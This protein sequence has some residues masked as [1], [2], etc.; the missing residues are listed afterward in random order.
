M[1]N[2]CSA[3][4]RVGALALL[5]PMLP[6]CSLVSPRGGLPQVPADLPPAVRQ[7]DEAEVDERLA[8]LVERL[9][10]R[11]DWA[12]YWQNG[13]TV[14]YGLGIVIQGTRAG[15]TDHEGKQADFTVSA[16]KAIGG[17]ANLLLRPIQ[18]QHG[19]DRV[20]ELP[21]ATVDD[22]RRRLVM[23]EEQLRINAEEAKNRWHWIRHALNVAVNAA[24]AVIV[25]KGFDDRTRAWRSFGVG[26]AVGE[27]MILSAPW[28]PEDDWDEY[29]S[30]FGAP[31]SGTKVSWRVVPTFGG[32][33]LEIS[34]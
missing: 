31:A 13:W 17:T 18:A 22:R 33:Q 4:A 2:S 6:A 7:L 27:A 14:F 10:H 20:R 16:V 8:F 26:T 11:R 32:A 24:G 19:A 29:Q 1:R 30:R 12:W 23:A 9:D 3:P 15:L 21:D 28:W 5:L 25:W 34:F